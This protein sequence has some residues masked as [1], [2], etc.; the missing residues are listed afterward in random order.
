MPGNW[1]KFENLFHPEKRGL[2]ACANYS[3][4]HIIPPPLIELTLICDTIIPVFG[5]KDSVR[6]LSRPNTYHM[7]EMPHAASWRS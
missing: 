2:E 4:Q 1:R 5:L 3:L 7:T 6:A